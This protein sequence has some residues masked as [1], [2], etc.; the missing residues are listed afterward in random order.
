M[1]RIH[2]L[3]YLLIGSSSLCTPEGLRELSLLPDGFAEHSANPKSQAGK[4]K[5]SKIDPL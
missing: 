4:K 3:S 2:W 1:D 5:S